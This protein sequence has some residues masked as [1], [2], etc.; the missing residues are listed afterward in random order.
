MLKMLSLPVLET[1]SLISGDRKPER[2]GSERANRCR[3]IKRKTVLGGDPRGRNT[4]SSNTVKG[5]LRPK[6]A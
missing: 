5:Q 1:V 3:G 4:S 2:D 6:K